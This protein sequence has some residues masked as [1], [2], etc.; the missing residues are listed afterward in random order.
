MCIPFSDFWDVK[1]I[2]THRGKLFK[3]VLK[4]W[5]WVCSSCSYMWFFPLVSLC[6]YRVVSGFS[7]FELYLYASSMHITGVK[8]C[9]GFANL[10]RSRK[11]KTDAWLGR[12][13]NFFI[14]LEMVEVKIPFFSDN[15]SINSQKEEKW[16]C[17]VDHILRLV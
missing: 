11:K 3:F 13:H 17:K 1:G 9:Y 4:F 12:K 16:K 6:M 10:Q 15:N 7:S 8:A 14:Q 5:V 2:E